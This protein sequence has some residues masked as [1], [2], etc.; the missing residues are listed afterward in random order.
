MV[1]VGSLELDQLIVCGRK[2]NG[3]SS[4]DL[5]I[6]PILDKSRLNHPLNAKKPPPAIPNPW[7]TGGPPGGKDAVLVFRT[8]ALS[9][10]VV[11]QTDDS[12]SSGSPVAGS[13]SSSSSN[14]TKDLPAAA[15]SDK[16]AANN[17]SSKVPNATL[18]SKN[19]NVQRKSDS[20]SSATSNSNDDDDDDDDDQD[21]N[22][23]DEV[24]S[25]ADNDD[26]DEEEGDGE[27]EED[28]DNDEAGTSQDEAGGQA[29]SGKSKK[30]QLE[31]SSSS[32]SL[33]NASLASRDGD[34]P[35]VDLPTSK[36]E[37]MLATAVDKKK[38]LASSS[39]QENKEN[40]ADGGLPKTEMPAAQLNIYY[41]FINTETRLLRKILN[42]HGMGESGSDSTDFNLLWTGIHLKPDILRNLA[43][44][45]RVNHF[46][47]YKPHCCFSYPLTLSGLMGHI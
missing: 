25:A 46:P 19:F 8:S 6:M 38:T 41:K 2:L 10:A 16:L 47:R 5:F 43:P 32:S 9:P 3:Y 37:P 12:G 11:S 18:P 4:L 30:R 42:A 15:S 26:D 36:S 24:D 40:R 44:Y 20:I 1:F 17:G 39:S 13:S 23:D 34:E 21:D 33:S 35:E 14:T 27:G 22:A 7:V 29:A 28:E 31:S 45:Q